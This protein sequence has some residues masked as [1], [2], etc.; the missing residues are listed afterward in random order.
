VAAPQPGTGSRILL[1]QTVRA[2]IIYAVILGEEKHCPRA[3]NITDPSKKEEKGLP[4]LFIHI[5]K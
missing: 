3:E 5:L 2:V 4:H 1:F